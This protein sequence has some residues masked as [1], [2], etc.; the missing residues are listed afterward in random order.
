[1]EGRG[2]Y[3]THVCPEQRN[4]QNMAPF[5]ARSRFASSKTMNGALPPN[6]RLTFFRVPD[7]SLANIFPTPVEPVKL[8]FFTRG[9]VANSLAVSRSLVGQTWIIA[10]GRPAL[11]AS[12]VRAMQL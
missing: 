3:Q 10:G 6:S 12:L 4:L 8:S 11:T 9:F 1:M 5:T 2:I 7:A